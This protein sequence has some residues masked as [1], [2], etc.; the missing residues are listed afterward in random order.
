MKDIMISAD[1]G[2][3]WEDRT[4]D[5]YGRYMDVPFRTG[6][7]WVVSRRYERV[8]RGDGFEVWREAL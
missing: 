4:F 7:G 2:L 6:T 3:R 8:G 5:T 1:G